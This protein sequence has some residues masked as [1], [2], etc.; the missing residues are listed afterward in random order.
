M[1]KQARKN[2]QR[3][4]RQLNS[5]AGNVS[6]Q[7]V[8]RIEHELGK[9]ERMRIPNYEKQLVKGTIYKKLGPAKRR[10]LGSHFG[11]VTPGSNAALTQQALAATTQAAQTMAAQQTL[12]AATQAA[13]QSALASA[14]PGTLAPASV[15][16]PPGAVPSQ[17]GFSAAVPSAS[18]PTP[19]GA[20]P[21]G[22]VLVTSGGAMQTTSYM[23]A[24]GAIN[25]AKNALLNAGQQL[26]LI[27]GTQNLSGFGRRR[28]RF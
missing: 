15:V 1:D 7:H 14:A 26:Q 25:S 13:T 18:V 6:K 22:S 12:A 9:I 27:A 3:Y 10:Q 23:D 4:K 11:N 20:G 2:F 8:G 5:F 16:P 19:G 21:P 24:A 17:P 28:R